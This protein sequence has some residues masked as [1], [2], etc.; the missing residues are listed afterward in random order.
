VDTGHDLEQALRGITL[1]PY[2]VKAT[3]LIG[4]KRRSG[5]NMFRHQLSTMAILLD[6]KIVDPVLLKA[7]VIHDLFED[8][9]TM[10]GTTEQDI[11]RIDAD[12]PAV[13]A[14]VI[15]VTIR[16]ID[17]VRE[18]KA[19][20][21]RR[22]MES[23]SRRA[24]ILKL[25]DR[26]SNL[27]ALGFVHDVAFV[28]RYLAETRACVLPYAESVSPDMFRELTDLVADRG[29]LLSLSEAAAD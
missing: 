18:P 27:T 19:E 13:Y 6:Y 20:Y 12:G 10:P 29:R 14:L 8:A 16:T 3:A 28:K 25:A 26:I 2:I 22:V 21:L 4:V 1:A 11:V 7:A 15:E 17:G 24:R 5:S 9:P 23:G